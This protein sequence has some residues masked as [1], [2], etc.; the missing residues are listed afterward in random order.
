MRLVRPDSILGLI[1]TGYMLA[2]LPLVLALGLAVIQVKRLAEQSQITVFQVVEAAQGGRLL[3]SQLTA[4]ERSA[5]QYLVLRDEELLDVYREAHRAFSRTLER[6]NALTLDKKRRQILNRLGTLERELFQIFAFPR[7]KPVVIEVR[8]A[9][10]GQM[11]ELVQK[12]LTQSADWVDREVRDLQR[13]AEAATL[14]LSW[15]IFAVIPAVIVLTGIFTVLIVRPLQHMVRAIHR[16]GREDFTRPIV[17]R[18]PRDLEAVGKRLDWLRSRLAE[19]NEQKIRFLRHVSHE[20]K[21]PLTALREGAELLSDQVIGPL[22]RE[23]QE[24]AAILRGNSLQL[25]RLI[26]DLLNFNQALSRN[27]KLHLETIRLDQVVK[28]IIGTQRLAWKARKLCVI[29][30]LAALCLPGDREKLATIVD[31]LLSN[32]IKFS[33]PGGT[34]EVELKALDSM[35]QLEVRDA[36]PG[37]DPRDQVRVFEAFYQGHTVAD[38]H[39][40]GSGLGLAIAKEYALAHQGRLE[41]VKLDRGGG[42]VRLSLPL[43]QE[44]S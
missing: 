11:L 26:E 10:F 35:A 24:V 21:T 13:L 3:S 33:P 40:K 8:V 28:E 17:V 29:P 18:G 22:N 38:G 7:E 25:Q 42:C 36:G 12:F 20:L 5:R 27:V 32:A 37:F 19:L 16:L 31:N 30:N 15:L 4:M 39:V 43:Q 2:L 34:I 1:L 6:L 41:I 14:R 44:S 9:D 23:Q